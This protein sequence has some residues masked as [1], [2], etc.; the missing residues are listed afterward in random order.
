MKAILYVLVSVSVLFGKCTSIGTI[1][2]DNH[3]LTVH[4]CGKKIKFEASNGAV[5]KEYSSPVIDKI[6]K[7]LKNTKAHSSVHKTIDSNFYIKSRDYSSSEYFLIFVIYNTNGS[8]PEKAS[9]WIPYNKFQDLNN[10]LK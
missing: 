5:S 1:V 4:K 10:L 6:S 8:W 2:G 9:V 3:E 7:L